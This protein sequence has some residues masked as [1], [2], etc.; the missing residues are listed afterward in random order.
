MLL[1]IRRYHPL[2]PVFVPLRASSAP[3]VSV[4]VSGPAALSAVPGGLFLGRLAVWSPFSSPT[5]T[6]RAYLSVIRRG[7]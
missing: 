6:R 4:R 1:D 2:I 3:R 7:K 5:G